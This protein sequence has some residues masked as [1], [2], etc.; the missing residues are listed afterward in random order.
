MYGRSIRRKIPVA[1]KKAYRWRK[2]WTRGRRGFAKAVKNVILKT[3]E[4]KYKTCEP[5]ANSAYDLAFGGFALNHNSLVEIKLIDNTAPNLGIHC[6]MSQGNSDGQRNGDE[7][8][9]KGIMFR[10]AITLPAD[11]KNATFKICLVEYNSVQGDPTV[12]TDLFHNVTGKNVLD[13]IQ[14][15][16][17]KVRVLGTYRYLPR[18]TNSELVQGQRGEIL[19]K[20]W[21]PFKRTLTFKEDTSLVY[22]KGMKERLSLVI[23]SYDN[24]SAF[25]ATT[26]GYIRANATIYYGDP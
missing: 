12:F 8:Y 24:N 26:I 17:W 25:E 13:P 19:V 4:K 7:I 22:T 15:D 20:K 9:A 6:T 1:K 3:A 11:R 14:Q 23:M 10:A 5:Q 18:D 21:I 16:R 2:K